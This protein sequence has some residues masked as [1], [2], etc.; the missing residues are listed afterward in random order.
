[1]ID[2]ID[3]SLLSSV[4]N[5]LKTRLNAHVEAFLTL[6]P[7][8]LLDERFCVIGRP[9]ATRHRFSMRVSLCGFS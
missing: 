6:L 2:A 8:L 7:P 1:M 3:E 5:D 4:K 9:A